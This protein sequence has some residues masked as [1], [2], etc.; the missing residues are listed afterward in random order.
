MKAGAIAGIVIGIVLVIIA[1]IVVVI[2]TIKKKGATKVV[3]PLSREWIEQKI[4][5]PFIDNDAAIKKLYNDNKL[6][7]S[8]LDYDIANK[9]P[10]EWIEEI[11]EYNSDI[12]DEEDDLKDKNDRGE[13][14]FVHIE[15]EYCDPNYPIYIATPDQFSAMEY[16][17][18]CPWLRGLLQ[19]TEG[20]GSYSREVR[21]K[22]GLDTAVKYYYTYKTFDPTKWPSDKPGEITIPK[23][24]Y[25]KLINYATMIKDFNESQHQTF[26]KFL[27]AS[28][29]ISDEAANDLAYRIIDLLTTNPLNKFDD[30][31][32]DQWNNM[33][34]EGDDIRYKYRL[35][36][37]YAFDKRAEALRL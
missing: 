8:D 26:D 6:I 11:E 35:P 16:L 23:S 28:L 24:S 2:I 20:N 27:S 25:E 14:D 22:E 4:E 31:F 29:G 32:I 5:N 37:L 34:P 18:S 10:I 19:A 12:Q 30:S 33:V 13:L 7:M 1:I 21:D 3:A 9:A 36:A 17:S 15:N